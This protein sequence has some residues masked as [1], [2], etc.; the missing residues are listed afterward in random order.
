MNHARRTK[1][2]HLRQIR[3]FSL[4][5]SIG[6]IRLALQELRF[7]TQAVYFTASPQKC[8][9]KRQ[10]KITQRAVFSTVPCTRSAFR[11]RPGYQLRCAGERCRCVCKTHR[12]WCICPTVRA[13]TLNATVKLA[14]EM[15]DKVQKHP[16]CFIFGF[17]QEYTAYI[18]LVV[19]EI[20]KVSSLLVVNWCNGPLQI[21]TD[22][23]T[24]SMR[25]FRRAT[26]SHMALY[27]TL[28]YSKA[29]T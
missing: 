18:R 6:N 14:N 8:I 28:E 20:H 17:G 13:Q 5:I 15:T 29:A 4:N 16:C 2:N 27:I 3:C 21:R 22:S 24:R 19:N 11:S 9:G 23:P 26:K 1:S 12:Y 10:S 7:Q 25:E